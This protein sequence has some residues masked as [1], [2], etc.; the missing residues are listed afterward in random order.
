MSFIY[1]KNNNLLF[2][3]EIVLL[4]FSVIFYFNY[5][6]LVTYNNLSI[7]NAYLLI[8]AVLAVS[9]VVNGIDFITC[10][11]ICS[12]LILIPLS[13]QYF[14]NT[15]YGLL[16]LNL[17]PIYLPE[18]LTIVYLYSVMMVFL[19][20]LFKFSFKEKE[21]IKN[22]GLNIESTAIMFN[23]IV[24][25]IFVIVAFPRLG[26]ASS[27]D[28][29]FDMLLP[30]HSWN[31]LSIVALLFNFRYLKSHIS[32]KLTYLFVIAWFLIDG[33]R[34]DV[35][36]IILG[37]S[38]L[39]LQ[40]SG[41]KA[42]HINVAFLFLSLIIFAILL[43]LIVVIRNN[44]PIT[45]KNVI[46]GLFTTATLSDVGYLCN[47]SVDYWKK[48]GILKGIL[49][50][51]NVLSAI[52]FFDSFDFTKFID[53]VHYLNP[54]GESIFSE[55]LLDFGFAGMPFVATLDFLIYRIIVQF[56]NKFFYY[57]YLVILCS[58]PRIVWYGRSY[59]YSSV[60][61]FVP[62][63]FI[64]DSFIDKHFNLFN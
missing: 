4:L 29:R 18:I 52:P 56:N 15:S 61:V 39:F 26:M 38:I 64:L 58:I 16:E 21:L 23:N 50:K 2:F 7:I 20:A 1:K 19:S 3:S 14:T 33:E 22:G 6:S 36:G 54:G 47:I 40:K 60:L 30:G 8:I 35:T 46:G 48:F 59:F 11:L 53:S 49:L 9:I 17:Y 12:E 32:V 24:A 31:Q 41:K 57:E 55:P 62:M 45:L 42:K 25:I 34:A 27:G 37:I 13:I 44:E 10:M 5:N 63:M 51:S 43:N 28:T